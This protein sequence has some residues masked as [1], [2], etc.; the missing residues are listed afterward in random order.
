MQ[1]KQER[2]KKFGC[3]FHQG[4]YGTLQIRVMQL[5]QL[6]LYAVIVNYVNATENIIHSLYHMVI[7]ILILLK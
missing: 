6:L 7:T 3:S 5:I 4:Y 1:D 2:R